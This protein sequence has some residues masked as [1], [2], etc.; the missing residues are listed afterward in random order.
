MQKCWSSTLSRGGGHRVLDTCGQ[1]AHAAQYVAVLGNIAIV[2]PWSG[3]L[4]DKRWYSQA[5][6]P[7]IIA[8]LKPSNAYPVEVVVHPIPKRV[9]HGCRHNA[10][11]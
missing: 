4:L 10:L 11:A 8:C 7:Q 3:A 9:R 1:T 5:A 6:L 2:R